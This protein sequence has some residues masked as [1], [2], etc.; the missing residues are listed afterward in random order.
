LII[1]LGI[2]QRCIVGLMGI[3]ILMAGGSQPQ[4]TLTIFLILY[5]TMYIVL[6]LITPAWIDLIAKVTPAT[7]RGRLVGFRS[8][9]AGAMGFSCGFFL[10]WILGSFPAPRNY[11]FVFFLAFLFQAISVVVQSNL[12]EAEPSH[13][14]PR[15]SMREF[16]Q[17]IPSV[18]EN[19]PPF[20]N[21]IIATTFLVMGTISVTFFTVYAMSRFHEGASVVGPFTLT[22]VAA[23]VVSAPVVG[24]L[25]DR[26]GNRIA[27]IVA[28]T[29]LLCASVCAILAPSLMWFRLVF[30][31]LGI[32]LGSE[33][34]AR[35]NLAIEFAPERSRAVYFGIMNAMLAPFYAVNLLGGWISDLFGYQ[36][37][38]HAGVTCSIAGILLMIFFVK[39]PR[40]I[41]ARELQV[42]G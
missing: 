41:V 20:R 37:V 2:F 19:H 34:M 26:Y 24:I 6:G 14:E 4:L 11:A 15:K 23:Q 9:L 10:T 40:A 30:V 38:F 27:L 35:Y 25:A 18:L 42:H 33:L 29:G 3:I 13:V 1:R 21:F 22:M 31:F 8:S 28:A 12:V 39:E 5:S 36:T 17:Q 16:L 32:N 7:K